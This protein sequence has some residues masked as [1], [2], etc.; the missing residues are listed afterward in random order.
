MTSITSPIGTVFHE[1]PYLGNPRPSS[2]NSSAALKSD[3]EYVTR[4]EDGIF[5][6]RSDAD[7]PSLSRLELVGIY[8]FLCR[9]YHSSSG[10]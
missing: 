7:G 2:R 8:R 3:P 4:I 1:N 5:G 6:R 9:H 10:T